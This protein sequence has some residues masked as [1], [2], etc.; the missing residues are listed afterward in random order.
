[1]EVDTI[2]WHEFVVVEQID[3]YEDQELLDEQA[4][5]EEEERK[6]KEEAERIKQEMIKMQIQENQAILTMPPPGM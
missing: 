5:V 3:L 2:D 1:M 6:A 4:K